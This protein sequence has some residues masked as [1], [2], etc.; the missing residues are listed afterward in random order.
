VIGGQFSPGADTLPEM[1]FH[2]QWG[3]AGEWAAAL[4]TSAAVYLSAS[5]IRSDRRARREQEALKVV[6]TVGLG[7]GPPGPKGEPTTCMIVNVN[8]G[9]GLTIRDVRVQLYSLE[10]DL[11]QRWQWDEV[12]PATRMYETRAPGPDDWA[13]YAS[14]KA[15]NVTLQITFVDSEGKRW[16]RDSEGR[17]RQVRGRSHGSGNR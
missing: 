1:S 4:G 13:R 11:L 12:S 16:L 8:N 2:W 7:G 15:F 5:T 6:P 3:S 17:I 14:G 9:G 10:G